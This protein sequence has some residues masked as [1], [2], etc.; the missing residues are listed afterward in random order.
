MQTKYTPFADEVE[1]QEA[2]EQEV[3]TTA[4]NEHKILQVNVEAILLFKF[5]NF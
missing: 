3:V 5:Y 2:T 1:Q 4:N